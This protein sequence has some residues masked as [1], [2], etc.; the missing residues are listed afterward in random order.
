ML[1]E[2]AESI[3]FCIELRDVPVPLWRVAVADISQADLQGRT[4]PSALVDRHIYSAE[5]T[6]AN[7][8]LNMIV[9]DPVQ[10]VLV[11]DLPVSGRTRPC[12][13][14]THISSRPAPFTVVQDARVLA[15]L[16]ARTNLSADSSSGEPYGWPHSVAGPAEAD[17]AAV[18]SR[19]RKQDTEDFTW[20]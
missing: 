3:P 17:S 5:A 1:F 19:V 10:L 7:P 6:H 8:V 15:L 2:P 18:L 9:A 20:S 13:T 11:Y 12:F 4:P 14:G 16:P